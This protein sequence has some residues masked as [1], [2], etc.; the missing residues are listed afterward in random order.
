MQRRA[1]LR[2]VEV[3]FDLR[4]R[5]YRLVQQVQ[6]LPRLAYRQQEGAPPRCRCRTHR[7]AVWTRS[8]TSSPSIPADRSARRT[9]AEDRLHS[10][11]PPFDRLMPRNN[12]VVGSRAKVHADCNVREQHVGS[13]RQHLRHRE[14]RRCHDSL[15][16]GWEISRRDHPPEQ[17]QE[18]TVRI[19]S[20]S[21]DFTSN[22]T[23]PT[24][25]KRPGTAVGRRDGDSP[26]RRSPWS[27]RPMERPGPDP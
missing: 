12:P 22:H 16:H 2:H 13:L 4:F 23:F 11:D 27:L 7:S 20:E 8:S 9:H 14:H 5:S 3:L 21:A 6:A 24:L 26:S 10:L 18:E 25:V 19:L 1:S 17:V 15:N